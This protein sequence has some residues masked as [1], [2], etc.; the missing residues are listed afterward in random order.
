MP[1]PLD[2]LI[3]FLAGEGREGGFEEGVSRGIFL[4]LI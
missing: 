1:V 3:C 4:V 2:R